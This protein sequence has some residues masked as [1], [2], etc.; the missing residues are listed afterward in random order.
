M[1]LGGRGGCDNLHTIRVNFHGPD[2]KFNV[3]NTSVPDC[4]WLSL[5]VDRLKISACTGV[6]NAHWCGS[7]RSDPDH[8]GGF[9]RLGNP[10]NY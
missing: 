6:G 10:A 1:E 9:A 7:Y 2:H 3:K 5:R 8:N 4:G